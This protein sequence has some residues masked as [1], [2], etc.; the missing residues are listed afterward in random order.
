MSYSTA[1]H[2]AISIE[3][4]E[5]DGDDLVAIKSNSTLPPPGSKGKSRD[6]SANTS[7]SLAGNIGSL[8]ATAGGGGINGAGASKGMRQTIGGIQTETRFSGGDTLDEPVSETIMRDLRTIY[9]KVIQVLRPTS[10]NAVLRDWDLWG[11]LI[12]CL[13][14]AVLLSINAPS[15]QSLSIFTGVFAIVWIGSLVVTL[16]AKLLGGKVSF[17]QS[18]C[19]LGYCIF[20]LCVAAFIS[21]FISILW[22]R[23]PICIVAFAWSIYAAINFLGGTRLEQDR[24]VLAVFPL[25]LFYFILGWMTLLS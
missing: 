1:E 21:L 25:F 24:A 10:D 8:P 7:P 2:Q 18:V 19:V 17:L 23:A 16:N 22:I 11:P 12:F 14:L 4:D 20:P 13:L 9:T 3:P 6:S 5:D 15:D